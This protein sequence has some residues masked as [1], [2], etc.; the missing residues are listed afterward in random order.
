[1]PA[2]ETRF[3]TSTIAPRRHVRFTSP[4][5]FRPYHGVNIRAGSSTN[6]RWRIE[7]VVVYFS[8]MY[9]PACQ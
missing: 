2:P 9:W 6:W 5:K 1:M 4:V 7:R 3:H 8:A